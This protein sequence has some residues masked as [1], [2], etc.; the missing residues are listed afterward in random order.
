MP[1]VNGLMRELA[2]NPRQQAASWYARLI[3]NEIPL[4]PIDLDILSRQFQGGRG[5]M[6]TLDVLRRS[7][8]AALFNYYRANFPR[9]PYRF[10]P[11][12]A[13]RNRIDAPT[14]ILFGTRD[15]FVLADG[16]RDNGRW[17]AHPLKAITTADA[18][19]WIHHDVPQFVAG[20]MLMWLL[21]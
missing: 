14:L 12:L 6:Q 16:L 11:A 19:H 5:L 9:P 20:N 3:Q 21:R 8:I 2:T 7:D 15:S 17:F 18:G 13:A 1:H 4:G 10:D